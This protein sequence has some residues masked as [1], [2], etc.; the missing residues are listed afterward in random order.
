MDTGEKSLYEGE[1]R[2]DTWT[3]GRTRSDL[4]STTVLTQRALDDAA[5]EAKIRMTEKM[6]NP[7]APDVV[8][9]QQFVRQLLKK[10]S[11]QTLSALR[12][13]ESWLEEEGMS[14]NSSTNSGLRLLLQ[15][16]RLLLSRFYTEGN[17]FSPNAACL[18]SQYVVWICDHVVEHLE[19]SIQIIE[20]SAGRSGDSAINAVLS[21]LGND[22]LGTFQRYLTVSLSSLSCFIDCF[23]FSQASCFQS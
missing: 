20:P 10:C 2:A 21:I 3:R 5:N 9:L 8:P 4:D 16:Q 23:S 19:F 11:Q 1:M 6:A 15:F 7:V 18:L 17:V 14:E 12:S 13:A 22:I